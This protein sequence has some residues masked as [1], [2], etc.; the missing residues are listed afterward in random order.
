MIGDLSRQ[1]SDNGYRVR[2]REKAKVFETVYTLGRASRKQM[3]HHL[4]MRPSS[5]SEAVRQLLRDKLLIERDAVRDGKQGR[6]EV[7][8]EVNPHRLCAIGIWVVSRAIAAATI[9]LKGQVVDERRVGIGE[10]AD[11]ASF[12]SAVVALVERL[13][14]RVPPGSQLLGVGLSLPGIVD[15]KNKK[16][17]Y[18]SRWKGV[19][20]LDLSALEDSFGVAVITRRMLDAELESLLIADR[21]KSSESTLLCHWGYGIGAAYAN[22]GFVLQSEFG[23]FCELGHLKS[24]S[25]AVR[26]CTCGEYDCI[27]TVAAGWALLHTLQDTFGEVGEAEQELGTLCANNDVYSLKAVQ[28]ACECMAHGLETL[29]RTL[30]PRRILVYGPFLENTAVRSALKSQ[31]ESLSPRY[32]Q[33]GYEFEVLLEDTEYGEVRGT[34]QPFFREA[35]RELLIYSES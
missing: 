24:G 34:T 18:N 32:A 33:G 20:D 4:E 30:F 9:N 19:C 3:F 23:S 13:K 27:E 1:L 2:D 17:T 29:Y 12:A 5:V 22:N 35:L 21:E 26:L 28:D 8:L 31:F 7:Q 25:D 14:A 15:L 11:N 16:W 6:P 10:E